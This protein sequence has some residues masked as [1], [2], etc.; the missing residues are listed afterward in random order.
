MYGWIC[1]YI[2]M[3]IYVRINRVFIIHND[4][5]MNEWMDRLI[6]RQM[7]REMIDGKQTENSTWTPRCAY[8][9]M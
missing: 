6:A 7:N 1:I 8:M 9:N 3:Y 2:Y 5:Q 4:L